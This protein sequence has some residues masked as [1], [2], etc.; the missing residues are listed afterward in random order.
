[1]EG[2]EIAYLG[3]ASKSGTVREG[4]RTQAHL[5]MSVPLGAK[6]KGKLV[7]QLAVRRYCVDDGAGESKIWTKIEFKLSF[8]PP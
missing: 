2:A 5:V 3:I 6:R 1:M 4:I 7:L 8:V